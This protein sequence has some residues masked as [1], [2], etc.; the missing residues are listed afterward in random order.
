MNVLDLFSGIGGFARA[1]D[2]A[3]F[4]TTQFVENHPR[5]QAVLKKHYAG[6]PIHADIRDF[7]C[8]ERDFDIIVGGSPCQGFSA[9]GKKFGITDSRS[10]LLWEMLRVCNECQPDYIVWENVR[11]ADATQGA[12]IF[13]EYIYDIGYRFDAEIVSAE[14]IGAPHQRERIFVV[15]YSHSVQQAIGREVQQTW[16][17]QIGDQI[18]RI[19]TLGLWEKSQPAVRRVVNGVSDRLDRCSALGNAVI[20]YCALIA[21]ERIKYLEKLR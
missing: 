11:N 16:A 20:P 14:E 1:C 2:M 21:L 7:H 9:G 10:G 17:D 13:C 5:C 8:R 18:E 15:A 19:R 12:R 3:R 4:E 6:I